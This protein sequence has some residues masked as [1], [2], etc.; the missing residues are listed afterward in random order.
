MK[1]RER[2]ADFFH[3]FWY[4]N[5]D[6]LKSCGAA[7]AAI[8]YAFVNYAENYLFAMAFFCPL[9][10]YVGFKINDIWKHYRDAWE[11]GW[12]TLWKH[13]GHKTGASFLAT[14]AL[15]TLFVWTYENYRGIYGGL[16]RF[17]GYEFLSYETAFGY[18][19]SFSVKN[20]AGVLA[21]PF[22]IAFL[23]LT[24]LP[25]LTALVGLLGGY[26]ERAIVRL[27]RLKEPVG[28][29]S[30]FAPTLGAA[31]G[32]VGVVILYPLLGGIGVSIAIGAGAIFAGFLAKRASKPE[33]VW[34]EK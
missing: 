1:L 22:I 27:F 2:M 3:A 14:L 11:D 15:L 4:D 19:I 10:A 12:K 24:V 9:L 32:I 31:A 8:G 30:A 34:M 20:A 13:N 28:V 33:S 16:D 29:N 25:S 6:V 7:L 18:N 21:T 5:F 23:I 17:A 26:A